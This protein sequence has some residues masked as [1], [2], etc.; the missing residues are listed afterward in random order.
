MYKLW[1]SKSD[2]RKKMGSFFK[3]STSITAC[4]CFVSSIGDLIHIIMAY[5]NKDMSSNTNRYGN[6]MVVSDGFYFIGSLSMYI[7]IIGKLFITFKDTTYK[8]SRKY[9]S[10]L[11][12]LIFTALIMMTLYIIAIHDDEADEFLQHSTKFVTIIIVIDFI[13]DIGVLSLF[14][15][16]L[17]QLLVESVD[18]DK[19][20]KYSYSEVAKNGNSKDVIQ[21]VRLTASEYTFEAN[22]RKLISLI[23]KQS[24]LGTIIILFNCA[25]YVKVFIDRFT[26]NDDS[27]SPDVA[28]ELSYCIRAIENVVVT[29]MLYLNF[30]FSDK[31]YYGLCGFCD[32][33]CYKCCTLC[34]KRNITRKTMDAYHRL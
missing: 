32:T 11:G 1:C 22:Q 34:T 5:L 17:Q 21:I 7:F 27:L 9:I 15:Y 28:F 29:F 30:A 24:V 13:I 10:F 19:M 6:I 31:L 23:T 4:F 25:F 12:L 26:V 2:K 3:Y 18:I 20:H 8:V 33:G 16:K 14:V